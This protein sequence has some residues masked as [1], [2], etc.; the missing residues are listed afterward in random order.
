MKVRLLG[1]IGL[2]IGLLCAMTGPAAYGQTLGQ[3]LKVFVG[4]SNLQGEGFLNRN[5]P[6]GV[7]DNE[8]FRDR[9]TLHGANVEV[10]GAAHGIGITGDLSFNRNGQHSDFS[11]GSNSIDT[12]VYY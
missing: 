11:G 1:L 7:F 12:D 2:L 6:S 9:T 10:T 8:F 5:T 3:N 4:Y